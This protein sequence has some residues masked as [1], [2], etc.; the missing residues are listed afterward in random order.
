MDKFLVV[1]ELI[2]VVISLFVFC[3]GIRFILSLTSLALIAKKFL[4]HKMGCD[5]CPYKQDHDLSQ[6][7]QTTVHVSGNNEY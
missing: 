4:K 1:S 3:I 2:V 7:M 6:S 5:I